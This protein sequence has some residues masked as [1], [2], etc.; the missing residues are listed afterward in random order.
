M[1]EGEKKEFREI[2]WEE[3]DLYYL[4]KSSLGLDK[5][6]V[7]FFCGKLRYRYWRVYLDDDGVLELF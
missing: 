1:V 5:V 2:K 4:L 6:I 3:S 7:N